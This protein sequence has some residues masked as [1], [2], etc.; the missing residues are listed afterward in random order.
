MLMVR[1]M[2]LGPLGFFRAQVLP[3]V[4]YSL[5]PPVLLPRT[6]FAFDIDMHVF[7]FVKVRPIRP[8]LSRKVMGPLCRAMKHS[9]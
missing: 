1:T 2:P 6:S 8:L 4:L 5:R 9:I 3:N 7:P